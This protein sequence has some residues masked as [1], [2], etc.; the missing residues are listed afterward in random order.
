MPKLVYGRNYQ[1]R[2]KSYHEYYLALGFLANDSNCE[3]RWE[4]NEDQGAWGS[5]GRI[6]CLVPS[7]HFPQ[8]FKFTAGRGNIYARINCN[9]YVSELVMTH[10]FKYNGKWQDLSSIKM[11]V[12]KE[13]LD[14]FDK[15]YYGNF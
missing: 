3:L 8:F 7:S 5:E 14:D 2:F 4:H 10:N 6:H 15:G 1:V 13:F 11:T 12:P 9:D